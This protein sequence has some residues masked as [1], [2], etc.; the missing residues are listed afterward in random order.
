MNSEQTMSKD[1][2]TYSINVANSSFTDSMDT[3]D[4]TINIED[5]ITQ[6]T[7]FWKV[8]HLRAL[9]FYIALTTLTSTTHGYD[10]SILNGFQSL[11]SWRSYLNYPTGSLLG[12]LSN[13]FIF[14]VILTFPVGPFIC[15]NWGRKWGIGIGQVITVFGSLLQ[16]MSTNYSTF[17]VSRLIIGA[18]SGIATIAS[19]TLISE[20]AYPKHREI[21][22]FSYNIQ[23]YTGAVIA[24]LMIYGM[25]DIP[26][27][28][29]WRGPSLFQGFLPLVQ[30]MGLKW[31]PESPR[32]LVSKGRVNEAYDI[33]WRY[34]TGC[35]GHSQGAILADF[36]LKE[37]EDAIESERK[38]A[39]VRYADFF[40]KKNMRKRLF[41][42]VFTAFMMQLSG[43]GLV[44]YYLNKVLN[45]IG[46]T[47]SKEQLQINCSL[48]V[49]NLVLA[50]II[51]LNSNRFGRRTM[52]LASTFGML[53][54]FIPWTVLSAYN[55]K[56]NFANKSLSNGVLAM[57]FLYYLAYNVGVNGLPFLY[58][59][60]MLPYAYRAK[61]LNIF[62]A[63][64]EIVLV[65][66]GFVNPIAMDAIAWKYYIVFCC[67]IAV[68][69]LVIYVFYPETSNRTLEE[70][71]EV[72]EHAVQLPLDVTRQS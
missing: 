15:D 29:S 27:N 66:N 32:F 24:S 28:Y 49:Y 43:N 9:N 14:G 30:L 17:F 64:Q 7:P 21:C 35:A 42:I 8:P 36:E 12:L 54:T 61:G 67:I 68:E 55:Q 44:S 51:C 65:Y 23:W 19:P 4:T 62:Q 1:I 58:I 40:I 10:G 47:G 52:F 50:S 59:T 31:I 69:V 16:G 22:T 18:G 5:L 25:M 37:I 11:E 57:I 60:E 56:H 20:L 70:V 45:S 53:A 48:M 39:K 71:A 2:S 41:L 13:A 63:I 3:N 6:S 46:I 38:T 26:S 33:L 72:F 34:H